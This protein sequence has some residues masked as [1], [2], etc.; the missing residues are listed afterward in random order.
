V[1]TVDKHSPI[2]IYYQIHKII[3]GRIERGLWPPQAQIPSER[4]LAEQYGVSRMTVRQALSILNRDGI[5]RREIGRGT[6][7]AEPRMTQR[8]NSLTSFTSE[9]RARSKRPSASVLSLIASLA[10]PSIAERLNVDHGKGIVVIERLR[11]ADDEPMALETSHIC[12]PGCVQLLQEDLSGSLYV[13]LA[14]KYGIVPTRARQ[15][16]SAGLSRKR[17]SQLLG[18]R[19]RVPVLHLRRLTFDQNDQAFEY[20]ESIYRNDKYTFEAELVMASQRDADTS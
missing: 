10:T 3:L 14:Q 6:F 12:F 7:V 20:V 11:L 1:D 2:P 19:R 17:E 16:I 9:M 8:L 13:L 18:I 5:L 4:E 15:Q